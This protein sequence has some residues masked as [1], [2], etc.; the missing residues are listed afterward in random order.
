MIRSALSVVGLLASVVGF[1]AFVGLVVGAWWA[2]QQAEQKV[3]VLATKAEA[4]AAVAERAIGLVDEVLDRAELDLAQARA[5]PS[6]EDPAVNP[7]LRLTVNRA[8]GELPGGMDRAR[9]AVGVAS[10]T[11]VVLDAAIAV[12]AERPEDQTALG[13]RPEQL[14]D[15]RDK[16]N[17]ASTELRRAR[18][19]LGVRLSALSP[20]E[21]NAV[22]Q[23]L[24]HVRRLTKRLRAALDEAR[25]RVQTA[26]EKGKVWSL[27]VAL[28]TTGL[29]SLAALGQLFMARA[30]VRGLRRTGA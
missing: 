11:V 22:Q 8:A 3:D 18:S 30:C 20:E 27:R 23:A 10:E 24:D 25:Q 14:Q 13:L 2:K 4:A 26:R 28:A 15:A 17:T 29:G 9:E 6:A 21:I 12:F 7:F 19:L 1:V 16:L 5:A